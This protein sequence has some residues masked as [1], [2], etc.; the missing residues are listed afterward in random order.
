MLNLPLEENDELGERGRV[1]KSTK[2]TL[3]EE[4]LYVH[5]DHGIM[6]TTKFE[7]HHEDTNE[8]CMNDNCNFNVVN[9][10]VTTST[11]IAE[12]RTA[13]V[14]KGTSSAVVHRS[15]QRTYYGCHIVSP[16]FDK[17]FQVPH[18]GSNTISTKLEGYWIG[19]PALQRDQRRRAPTHSSRQSTNRKPK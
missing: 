19:W 11:T 15:D 17:L 1:R 14:S 8:P 18:D 13:F 6:G 2:S 5:L 10:A 3:G 12:I 4:T 7:S 9:F 16:R